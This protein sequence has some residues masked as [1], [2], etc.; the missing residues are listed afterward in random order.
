MVLL[1]FLLFDWFCLGNNWGFGEQ[2]GI[3][4]ERAVLVN[5]LS[6]RLSFCLNLL[7]EYRFEVSFSRDK[8]GIVSSE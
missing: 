5:C 6:I 8:R 1:E 2:L 7:I 3:L 4:F